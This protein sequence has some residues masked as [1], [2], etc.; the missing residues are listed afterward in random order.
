[1]IVIY[2]QFSSKN[3]IKTR[4]QK[5]S[6]DKDKNQNRKFLLRMVKAML[7]KR[8]RHRLTMEKYFLKNYC[9]R[10]EKKQHKMLTNIYCFVWL[11]LKD[12]LCSG[13]VILFRCR[14][15]LL[16]CTFSCLIIVM[17][18]KFHKRHFKNRKIHTLFSIRASASSSAS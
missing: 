14:L 15:V 18:H 1:M 7:L 12:M 9:S 16:A 8:T 2:F 11:V 13:W 17:N 4:K 10:E 6:T 5:L 3:K